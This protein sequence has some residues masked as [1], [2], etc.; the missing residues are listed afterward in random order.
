MSEEKLTG[1]VITDKD[2]KDES[3]DDKVNKKDTDNV[4]E[5]ESSDKSKDIMPIAG[6]KRPAE[7]QNYKDDDEEEACKEVK[8]SFKFRPATLQSG[9][10]EKTY[11]NVKSWSGSSVGSSGFILQPSKLSASNNSSSLFKLDTSHPNLTMRAVNPSL[12]TGLLSNKPDVDD[13]SISEKSDKKNI[14]LQFLSTTTK[15]SSSESSNGTF[16][17]GSNLENKVKN[18][19]TNSEQDVASEKEDQTKGNFITARIK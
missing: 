2:T 18:E 4:T 17:F 14:F 8:P 11:T 19:Q 16:L 13:S 15:S 9:Q 1:D 12:S 3:D 10:P 5:N 7:S 6:I